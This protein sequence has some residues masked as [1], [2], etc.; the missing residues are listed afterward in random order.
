MARVVLVVCRVYYY[1]NCSISITSVL[2]L[3]NGQV[4]I[5]VLLGAWYKSP[6]PVL[7]F[8]LCTGNRVPTGRYH[9]LQCSEYLVLH[10]DASRYLGGRY[11]PGTRVRITTDGFWYKFVPC[12]DVVPTGHILLGAWYKSSHGLCKGFMRIL[13]VTALSP[14]GTKSIRW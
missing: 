11:L 2:V 4:H 7:L 9:Y 12:F 14:G 10:R 5:P 6:I 3:R 8:L 13:F 1:Y